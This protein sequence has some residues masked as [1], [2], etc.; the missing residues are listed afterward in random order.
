MVTALVMMVIQ[1]T[2]MVT[3]ALSFDPMA[4]MT[5]IDI[6]YSTTNDIGG[7]QFQVNGV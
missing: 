6:D 4:V 1:M 3:V 5:S 7:Y 2:I